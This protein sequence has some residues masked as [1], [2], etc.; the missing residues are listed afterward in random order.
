MSQYPKCV[1]CGYCCLKAVCI[2]V[3]ADESGRCDYLE[4]REEE[5]R[6]R[7]ALAEEDKFFALNVY[8]GK[9]CSSTL[10]TWRK[11]VKYRG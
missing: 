6:Y 8:I 7:C 4:W 9:G 2:S 11:E 5:G 1:G 3:F 10:N